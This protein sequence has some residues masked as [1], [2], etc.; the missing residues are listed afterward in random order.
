MED[1]STGH[2]ACIMIRRDSSNVKL[3]RISTTS[4]ES[5]GPSATGKRFGYVDFDFQN[6]RQNPKELNHEKA[7]FWRSAQYCW[8]KEERGTSENYIGRRK[9]Q[10]KPSKT[11]TSFDY[12]GTQEAKFVLPLRRHNSEPLNLLQHNRNPFTVTAT[13]LKL[14]Q[15]AKEKNTP[16]NDKK[17][18]HNLLPSVFFDTTSGNNRPKE[19][20]ARE[21]S[22]KNRPENFANDS[23]TVSR[24]TKISKRN[25]DK[26]LKDFEV[27]ER[28]EI[29]HKV[30]TSDVDHKDDKAVHKS[31]PKRYLSEQIDAYEINRNN[32][33]AF[34][35]KITIRTSKSCPTIV[36]HECG[37]YEETSH[38]SRAVSNSGDNRD[39]SLEGS[40]ER[41]NGSET[42]NSDTTSFVRYWKPKQSIVKSK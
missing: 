21:K 17:Q 31:L 25:N 10:E 2:P 28:V 41:M 36:I 29:T 26:A 4:S 22:I 18:F 11:T 35:R 5:A 40:S 8:K 27:K 12:V 33:N 30:N 3:P 34:P 16:K 1:S 20:L 38:V 9:H 15:R 13:T 32:H 7:T 6:C 37:E 14:N 24:K 23:E 39:D 42:L 19:K